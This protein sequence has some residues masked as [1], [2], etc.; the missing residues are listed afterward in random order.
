MATFTEYNND[1]LPSSYRQ[2][3][4]EWEE[5]P[6]HFTRLDVASLLS[7][8]NIDEVRSVCVCVCAC[9]CESV[10]ACGHPH[11]YRVH[12]CVYM[13]CNYSLERGERERGVREMRLT[14]VFLGWDGVYQFWGG[15]A[16]RRCKWTRP[17]G[18]QNWFNQLVL[19]ILG[20]SHSC[21]IYS[22][23]CYIIRSSI[24]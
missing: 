10:C 14:R 12:V 16:G 21:N 13:L 4:R 5:T 8:S 11:M 20:H 23:Y 2:L 17:T 19:R 7:D 15:H 22:N 3:A 18:L 9:V 24:V 1:P 6:P